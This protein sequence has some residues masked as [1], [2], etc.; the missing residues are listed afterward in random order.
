M[1]GTTNNTTTTKPVDKDKA[2]EVFTTLRDQGHSYKE[3][4][5]WMK[6]HGYVSST[7]G[8][9]FSVGYLSYLFSKGNKSNTKTVT[10]ARVTTTT[11]NPYTKWDIARIV[12]DSTEFTSY[13]RKA[14]IR[15]L[16]LF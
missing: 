9:P 12:A 6:H 8:Q 5:S 11:K 4:A 7:T 15:A 10:T 13:Q 2:R 14:V 16:N 1:F 3:A